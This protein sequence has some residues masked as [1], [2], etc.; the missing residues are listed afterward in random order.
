[1]SGEAEGPQPEFPT[2][3]RYPEKIAPGRYEVKCWV[4]GEHM[5]VRFKTERDAARFF[6]AAERGQTVVFDEP[7][8]STI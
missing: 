3:F 6:R 2:R 7:H 1:M 8:G 5:A 4:G